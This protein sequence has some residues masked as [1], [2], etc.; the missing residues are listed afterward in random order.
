M[1]VPAPANPRMQ[2]CVEPS[3]FRSFGPQAATPGCSSI[4]RTMAAMAL[5]VRSGS[6]SRLA[7]EAPQRD[8]HSHVAIA[9]V[10][11]ALGIANQNDL[12]HLRGGHVGTAV[13]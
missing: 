2:C 13:R 12:R 11:P 4:N 6:L 5:L 8:S 3:P 10:K 1:K 7:G 9:G